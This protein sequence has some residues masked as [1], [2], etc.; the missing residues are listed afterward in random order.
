[1]VFALSAIGIGNE[2]VRGGFNEGSFCC[3]KRKKSW[4]LWIKKWMKNIEMETVNANYFSQ[5]IAF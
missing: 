1:M 4:L 3:N 5:E 2:G